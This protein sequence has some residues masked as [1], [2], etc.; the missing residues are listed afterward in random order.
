MK[1]FT[2][3]NS[4]HIVVSKSQQSKEGLKSS[5]GEHDA[6][7]SSSKMQF[8]PKCSLALVPTKKEKIVVL[9]CPKCGQVTRRSDPMVQKFGKAKESIVVIGNKEKNIQ[10]LSRTK[11]TCQKCGHG[12]AF[13]WMVQT[14]GGDE[15]MTQ[16]FRC[17]KCGVTWRESS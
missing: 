8:C 2:F 7:R 1:N 6:G 4:L 5:P 3:S 12:E 9:A 14:R 11:V 15:A 16:F 13:Y 10:T 17:A